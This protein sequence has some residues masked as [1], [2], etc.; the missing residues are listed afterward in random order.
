[1]IA[2]FHKTKKWPIFDEDEL[3][4]R[5]KNYTEKIYEILRVYENQNVPAEK[6]WESFEKVN[7]QLNFEQIAEDFESHYGE[8][9]VWSCPCCVIKVSI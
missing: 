8:T 5:I 3:L 1:M 4:K 6:F 9:F 2:K 7:E